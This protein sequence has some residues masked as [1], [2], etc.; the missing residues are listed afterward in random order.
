MN[1][2][3]ATPIGLPRAVVAAAP[4]RETAFGAHIGSS[5][6]LSDA[7]IPGPLVWVANKELRVIVSP[8]H[9]TLTKNRGVGPVMVNQTSNGE[10]LLPGPGR[11][12]RAA[13]HISPV[14]NRS[15]TILGGFLRRS[16]M[17]RHIRTWMVLALVGVALVCG[18]V[19]AAQEKT[20]DWS[21]VQIKTTKVSGNIYMLEGQGGN[22]AAP[23][24]EAAIVIVDNQFAPLPQKIHAALKAS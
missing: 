10:S 24:G 9:A 14:T 1:W 5:A 23:V 11:G 7:T 21:K 12:A 19:A 8:L 15:D 6:S 2:P 17:S 16:W 3:P 20:P 22:I 13:E 18:Q 4:N